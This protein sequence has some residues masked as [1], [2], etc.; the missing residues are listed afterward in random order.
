[1]DVREFHRADGDAVRALWVASGI[2][3]RPGDDDASLELFALR[4]AGMFLLGRP[5]DARAMLARL[6]ENEDPNWPD[7]FP[8]RDAELACEIDS[9][10][11]ALPVHRE[12][13]LLIA[14]PSWP[15]DITV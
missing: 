15:T 11:F 12:D 7:W 10:D 1:M 2:R 4:N 8:R 14:R 6:W 9:F 13:G 5:T 3:I